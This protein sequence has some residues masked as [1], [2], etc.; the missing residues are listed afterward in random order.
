MRSASACLNAACNTLLGKK[1]HFV[2]FEQLLP[3]YLTSST[4]HCSARIF[5]D[6]P[7]SPTSHTFNHG[8]NQPSKKVVDEA[9]AA[10]ILSTCSKLS[11]CPV[12][13][14]WLCYCAVQNEVAYEY[15]N[16]CFS[17]TAE[18]K[19]EKVSDNYRSASLRHIFPFLLLLGVLLLASLHPTLNNLL[20]ASCPMSV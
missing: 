1:A 7:C 13:V 17:V 3:C 2:H 12:V 20:L 4:I 19:Y 15:F 6:L 10:T 5:A 9:W 11:F 18:R 16:D 14:T 8:G